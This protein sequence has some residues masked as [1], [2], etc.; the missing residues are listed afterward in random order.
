[1]SGCKGRSVGR[2]IFVPLAVS[3][4]TCVIGRDDD[5]DA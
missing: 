4:S 2:V 5:H 1:V 3:P